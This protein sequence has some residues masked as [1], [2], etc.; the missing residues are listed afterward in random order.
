ME[1]NQYSLRRFNV[2]F[3]HHF[4]AN[5]HTLIVFFVLIT[6]YYNHFSLY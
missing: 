2:K 5:R 3:K 1:A 4:N 6:P